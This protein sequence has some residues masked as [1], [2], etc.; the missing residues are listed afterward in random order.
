MADEQGTLELIALELN[1][2]LQPLQERLKSGKAKLLLAEL[3]YVVSDA[4][5]AAISGS[6]T[7]IITKAGDLLTES[8]KLADA[9]KNDDTAQ[10]ITLLASV[11]TRVGQVIASFVDLRNALTGQG[12]AGDLS[13]LPERLFNYLLANYFDR[14]TGLNEILEFLGILERTDFNVGSTNPANPE[15][16]VY[17]YIFGKVF[18]WIDD[19]AKEMKTQFDWGSNTFDGSKLFPRLETFLGLSGLPV[20]YFDTTTPKKLDV[21][22][23]ELTPDTSVSPR[24]LLVAIKTNFSTG[25]LTFNQ[26]DLKAELKLAVS[27]PINAGLLIQPNGK[28]TVKPPSGSSSISG[29]IGVKVSAS[30][31]S[32]PQPFVLL[33]QAG[34]SR[35]EFLEAGLG[36]GTKFAWTGSDAQGDF[37]IEGSLKKGK[38]VLS[39][40]EGDSFLQKILPG[41]AMEATFDMTIGYATDSGFFFRGSSALEIRLPVHVSIG[42]IDLEAVTIGLGIE[43][44]ALPV[45]LGG[46]VKAK[47][48]PLTAVVQNMGLKATFTFPSGG[49]NLGPVNA[50]LGFKPPTGVGLSIDGGGFKGGGFLSFDTA[51]E[52][53]TG[54]LELDFMGMIAIRAIGLITT[55]MPDGKKGFSMLLIIT[56]DFTPIQLGFGFT[57]N[58]VGGLLGIARTMVVDKIREGV[59]TGSL[60]SVLFPTNII[61]NANRIISDLR[62]IFPVKEGQFVFGPMAKLGWG[63]PSLL[64]V[65]LGIMLEVPNSFK[66]VILGIVR[67]ILPDEKAAILKIQVNFMGAFEADKKLISFDA[68]LFD[69]RLLTLTLSGGMALRIKYGDN[70]QF[71]ITVGGFH[72]AYNPPPLSL[73]KIDRLTLNLLGGNNPRLTLSTYFAV[74]SNT[75][76]F[77]A[78]IELYARAWKFSVEGW[79]AFDALFQFSPFYFIVSISAGVAIKAGSAVLFSIMLALTL[80]GPTP[81]KARGTASFRILFIK[82]KV[83]FSTTWGERKDTTLPDKAVLDALMPA[84]KDR[85]NWQAR[86]PARS[87]LLV[88]LRKLE[89][90]ETDIIAHPAGSL[91]VSQKV[92]PLNMRIDKFGAYNPSDGNKFEIG[93]V[94]SKGPGDTGSGEELGTQVVKEEFAPA[95]FSE[96]DQAKKLSAKSFEQLPAGVKIQT[97]SQEVRTHKIVKRDVNYETQVIDA[98]VPLVVTL[99]L[100]IIEKIFNALLQGSAVAQFDGSFA[101][102]KDPVLAPETFTVDQESFSV[103]AVNTLKPWDPASVLPSQAEAEAYMQEMIGND[104]ALASQVQ[105]VP[106][107]LTNTN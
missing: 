34:G 51:N 96:M 59:K 88:S 67:A 19:P 74:T 36:L 77:G 105:V 11:G 33:G 38:V 13:K 44:G 58:G 22:L 20:I 12:I 63:V 98:R 81:W 73:P 55:R 75:V 69:S 89:P 15:F 52:R 46:D 2:I 94:V 91:T 14:L 16:T 1:I 92:V 72:P 48:G 17:K 28:L 80:E 87:R 42:P 101:K 24:G 56:T 5:E 4:Q 9:I 61:A 68:A 97:G 84:L 64:I 32:P 43:S 102:T 99:L 41:S 106:A 40:S 8:N 3:G 45:S 86:L 10:I 79:L 65:D 53:Y 82:I 62:A 39:G 60:N 57:L 30:R 29:E 70:P 7:N 21:V 76:Q 66:F 54:T 100:G 49:G 103:V 26:G 85:R 104:A 27:V 35:I 37:S 23:A 95:Q 31:T 18:D 78:K 93:K 90:T 6:L 25:T 83:R 47:L 50:E 71:L 107:Y